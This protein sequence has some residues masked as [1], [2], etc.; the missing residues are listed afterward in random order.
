MTPAESIKTVLASIFIRRGAETDK[1]RL[2]ENLSASTKRKLED[3][4]LLRND[5]LPVLASQ[6]AEGRWV[7]IST[8]R[9][10]MSTPGGVKTVEFSDLCEVSASLKDD[11]RQGISEKRQLKTLRL[12]LPDGTDVSIEVESGP[13]FIGIWNL[14]KHVARKRAAGTP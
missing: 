4:I 2:Y 8:E 12:F 9:T 5:E 1:T 14:L 3:L 11:A 6:V 7:F 13:P 10:I